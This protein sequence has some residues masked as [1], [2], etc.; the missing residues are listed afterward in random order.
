MN[1]YDSKLWMS[2]LDETIA[3]LP[4]LD[5]IAGKS[6]R[7]SGCTGL[8]CSVVVDVLNLWNETHEE[9]I[10]VLAA[11]RNKGKVDSRFAP[12]TG[13][14]WFAFVP[15]DASSTENA[16]L[17]CGYIRDSCKICWGRSK[18]ETSHRSREERL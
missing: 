10:R 17:P 5:E 13:E 3:A 6:V 7:V 9:K 4:E 14:S 2:D 15:Y 11:A 16:F 8:I 18:D 12:H 1:I